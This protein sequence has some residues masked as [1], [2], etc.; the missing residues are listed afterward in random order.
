[1]PQAKHVVQEPGGTGSNAQTEAVEIAGKTGTAQTGNPKNPTNAW[2]IGFAPY[3]N[4][5]L[6]VCVF[7]ENGLGNRDAAPIAREV[8]TRSLALLEN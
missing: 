5:M 4:P 3:E 7:V 2:F 8:L 6:A 1:M